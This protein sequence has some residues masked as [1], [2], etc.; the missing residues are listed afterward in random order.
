MGDGAKL[1]HTGGKD[2]IQFSEGTASFGP[3]AALAFESPLAKFGSDLAS[4]PLQDVT[5]QDLAVA[6]GLDPSEGLSVLSLGQFP[7]QWTAGSVTDMGID[8]V[9]LNPRMAS[10]PLPDGSQTWSNRVLRDVSGRKI[11]HHY[12][13]T[14][15][16][17]SSVGTAL[18]AVVSAA[19]PI[20]VEQYANGE[21]TVKG[22]VDLLLPG[23]GY[24][25]GEVLFDDPLY[26]IEFFAD[27]VNIPMLDSLA[28]ILPSAPSNCIPATTNAGALDIATDCLETHR[29]AY[30]IFSEA[31]AA[32]TP[33]ALATNGV[34]RS[35]PDV[36]ALA[37]SVLNA[38][39]YSALTPVT[40]PLGQINDLV[41]EMGAS[42]SA[43]DDIQ[44]ILL[45]YQ[46]LMRAR[47]AVANGGLSGFPAEQA[48][49]DAALAEAAAAAI[50][51][52]KE[53]D[54]VESLESMRNAMRLLVEAESIRTTAGV[55][56][57]PALIRQRGRVLQV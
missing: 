50:A 36:E 14:F 8:G 29:R 22:R 20:L 34:P 40:A 51:R 35:P 56:A 33:A 17:A 25:R 23:N 41:K 37:G 38:W 31:V 3:G 53:M 49:L 47:D 2:R 4:L 55:A 27:D 57:N 1:I 42:A 19:S 28:D 32:S 21:V 11:L 5:A 15:E 16:F 12:Y 45:Y 39:A 7:M 9:Q 54:A 48:E 26:K 46:A 13:G 24:V 43:S 18:T 52:S 44:S 6:F 10:F 30:R